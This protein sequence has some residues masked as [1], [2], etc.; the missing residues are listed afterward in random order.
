[1]T[2]RRV[3]R[4]RAPARPGTAH[5]LRG[6]F[7]REVPTKKYNRDS[8]TRSL[9]KTKQDVSL[10]LLRNFGTGAPFRAIPRES[11]IEAARAIFLLS[12]VFF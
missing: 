2:A 11:E 9:K 7:L 12:R 5:R 4:V 10:G 6:L 8:L 3:R 1:M